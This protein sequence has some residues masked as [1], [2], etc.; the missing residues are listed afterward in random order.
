MKT[1]S[2]PQTE[3]EES[4]SVINVE[5]S[6]LVLTQFVCASLVNEI[7]KGLLYKKSQ[8]PYPY[9]WLKNIIIKKREQSASSDET[10]STNLTVVNHFRVV[11]NAYDTMESLM[12]GLIK[13]FS[14]T[15]EKI[16][17]VLIV[18]GTT[19]ECPK[20]VFTINTLPVI[21]GHNERNHIAQLKKYQQKILR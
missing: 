14:E 12:T 5:C 6:D 20:E 1:K 19:P 4:G 7:F 9:N 15:V 21:Q 13:E 18:F 8:I 17:E 2:S 16:I 11:S 10:K 3:N